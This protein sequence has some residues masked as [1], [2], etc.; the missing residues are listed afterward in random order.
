MDIRTDQQKTDDLIEEYLKQLELSSSSDS[1]S[2]I[3]TRL[4]SLQGINKEV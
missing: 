1:V 2:E 3:Q 4:R